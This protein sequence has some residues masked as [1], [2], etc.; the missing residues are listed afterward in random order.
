VAEAEALHAGKR[1]MV[2]QVRVTE[3]GRRLFVFGTVS[4]ILISAE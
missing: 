3:G 4:C 2:S 1:M